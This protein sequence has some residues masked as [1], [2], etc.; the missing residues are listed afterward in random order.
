MKKKILY[1]IFVIIIVASAVVFYIDYNREPE[2]PE[3]YEQTPS[4]IEVTE[5]EKEEVVVEKETIKMAPD[6][7]LSKKRKQ[8]NNNDI[9]GRLEIPDLF[10][11]LVVKTDNNSFYLDHAVDRT[12]DIRGTEF[13]DYR[14]KPT[15][16]QVNIYG[17]NTR[18]TNIKVA[19]LKLEKFL[20]KNFFKNN[21]YII[22]QYDGGKSVYKIKAIKE[23]Y[24]SNREHMYTDYKGKDFVSHVKRMTTGDGLI[25]SRSDVNV[26]EDSKI[27]VLQT[28]SH[29]WDNALYTIIGVKID[30]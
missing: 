24:E 4:E 8:Y 27:I 17:H 11:V 6:V 14:I 16:K 12:Y 20:D 3:I 10:N 26:T 25:N 18:D 22:F 9:I 2:T 30:Y 15:S 7:N 29:H 19:F 5:E 1:I 28:C 23:V 21:P 13:L